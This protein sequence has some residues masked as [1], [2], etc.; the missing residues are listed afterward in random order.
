MLGCLL[1]FFTI[2]ATIIVL[3]LSYPAQIFASESNSFITIVNPVRISSYTQNPSMSLAAEYDE[4]K[5]RDF[6]ATWLLTYDAITN[7]SLSSILSS[8]D[9]RQELGIFLEVT[10]NYS[11][12]SGVVY[13]KTNSWHHA[14]ALFLSGYKQEDRKK[15]I[16]KVFS[17]FKHKFGHYPRSVGGWW[18]DSSSLSYI[19]EKY[20]I[21]GVL[22]ISDQ[23]DLDNYQVWGTPW[24]IPFYPSKIHAGMP[25]DV[26]NRLDIVTFRWAAR[27]P[28]NGYIS[29]SE[30]QA[31]LYSV[32]DYPQVGALNEYFERL[33][34]LYSV[35]KKYNK[36]GHI[37][38]G[39]E[40][41][42]SPDAF[43]AIFSKRLDSVKKFE[44]QGVDVL[45][46]EQFSDWYRNEFKKVSPSHFIETDDLLGTPK[47]AMWYQSA[48]YRLGLVY[49]YNL[50][51]LRIVDLRPYLNSFEE[52]FYLSPNKQ[53]NLSINLPYAIDYLN[54]KNSVWEFSIGS[55]KSISRDGEDMRVK[56]E[57][58]SIVFRGN[59]ILLPK[60]ISLPENIKN[61][62]LITIR[63]SED[64]IFI[65]P[66]KEFD[67][68]I[69]GLIIADFSFNIPFA[70]KSRLGNLYPL[71]L[72]FG[73]IAIFVIIISK[74]KYVKKYYPIIII[75]LA[76]SIGSYIFVKA[77]TKYYI[78]QS[79]I[80]GLSALSRFAKGRVLAY[81]KD[82]LRCSFSTSYKPAAAAGNKAYIE[83]LSKQDMLLDFSFVTARTSQAAR[84][85]IES[86]SIDYI[87]LVKYEDYIERLPYLPQDLGLSKLYENANV[88]IWKVH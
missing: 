23:F 25:G 88:E 17:E 65:I 51:T 15:L 49:N 54:D 80:D 70:I 85:V 16:D 29:P 26:L 60:D 12:N 46:M 50:E 74:R 68:P 69:E 4:I 38:I 87:Y 63:S 47:K 53:F 56:F 24:S 62:K 72:L 6:P 64:G 75:I 20:G 22:G 34:E 79:E 5:K 1:R 13:N 7:S 28:L 61:S 73:G 86:K 3:C 2:A 78:S 11:K 18:V 39:L 36:F 42:S 52:P 19:K 77:N 58:G 10:E 40:A 32:Q 84:K 81:D 82:C 44:E 55:L 31:S 45:N 67:A 59:E 71:A 66:N 76:I 9:A 48:F 21:T 35:Q 57:K 14:K 33:I 37:T 41:D 43:E 83:R 27:D 8:M 30:K